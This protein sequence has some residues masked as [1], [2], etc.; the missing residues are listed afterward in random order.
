MKTKNDTYVFISYASANR[1]L[2]RELY[3]RLSGRWHRLTCWLDEFDIPVDDRVFQEHILRGVQ[4]AS[5]LVM[6]STEE[7]RE[8]LYVGR[9]VAEARVASV[10]VFHYRIPSDWIPGTITGGEYDKINSTSESIGHVQ[11][12]FKQLRI[13]WLALRIKLRI[14][15]PFWL[16]TLILGVL[17]AGM[18]AG[19]YFL[20]KNITTVVAEAIQRNLPDAAAAIAE[21]QTTPTVQDPKLAAPFY[22]TPDEH[23]LMVDF[24]NDGQLDDRFYYDIRPDDERVDIQQKEGSLVFNYPSSCLLDENQWL[25]ETEIHSRIYP[26]PEIQYLGVRIRSLENTYRKEISISISES[27]PDRWRTG[28][29]WAFSD[30]VTPFFRSNANLP[31]EDFYAYLPLDDQWHAY[32][33]LLDP[34]AAQLFYYVDGQ[35][36]DTVKLHHYDAWASAPL[37]LLTYAVAIETVDVGQLSQAGNSS[38]EIEQVI[39]GSFHD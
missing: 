39:I 11:S 4:N 32:E 30:H 36:I 14:T 23:L 17:I 18:G 6:V 8:S 21:I 33:I 37:T 12:L 34:D 28:F 27:G 1:R 7:A 5:A 16:S 22:F 31:E 13:A 26:L 10:P 29:G 25:C 9:E 24:E 19:I 2:A 35:L 15:Q 3:H 38:L 20:G